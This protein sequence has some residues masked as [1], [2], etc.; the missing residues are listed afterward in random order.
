MLPKKFI[1]VSVPAADQNLVTLVN[2]KADLGITVSTE[3]DYLTRQIAAASQ[4]IA[5]YCGRVFKSE[6]VVETLHVSEY[7][8]IL[9]LA[10]YPVTAITSVTIDGV[11]QTSGTYQVDANSGFLSR[12]DDDGYLISWEP[13]IV[14]V[15]YVGGYSTIPS[16]LEQA[17]VSLVKSRRFAR[18]RDPVLRSE[19][20]PEVG[21][22][23]YWVSGPGDGSLPPG[24]SGVLDNYRRALY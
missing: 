10:R 15:S 21:D 17:C 22:F 2:L 24:V 4:E 12:K 19:K 6:T 13:G 16:D 9:M 7:H 20:I 3:D 5:T 23:A 11:T 1:T 18:E 8:E 14:V